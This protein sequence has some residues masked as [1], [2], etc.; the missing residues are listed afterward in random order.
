[1]EN[2]PWRQHERVV[3]GDEEIGDE[4]FGS[5]FVGVNIQILNALRG[6]HVFVHRKVATDNFKHTE[7]RLPVLR[8]ELIQN[9]VSGICH[10]GGFAHFACI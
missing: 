6:D 7:S 4:I 5:R 9:H 10:D 8:A 2:F 3:V 1:M